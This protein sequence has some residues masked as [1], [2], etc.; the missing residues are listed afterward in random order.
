MFK[1]IQYHIACLSLLKLV[2]AKK[3][4]KNPASIHWRDK[5]ENSK[6]KKKKN[7]SHRWLYTDRYRYFIRLAWRPNR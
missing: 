6:K 5:Y 1:T 3:T 2:G 7:R 4:S